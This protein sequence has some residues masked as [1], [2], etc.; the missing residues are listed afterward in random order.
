M[1][2]QKHEGKTH[3]PLS[4]RQLQKRGQERKI[5]VSGEMLTKRQKLLTLHHTERDKKHTCCIAATVVLFNHIH[6][7]ML[8]MVRHTR[9][10]RKLF[11]LF[12]Y[13]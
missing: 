8:A 6:W 13:I 9:A 2:N 12:Y 1:S 5:R 4:V 3:V 11:L 7:H 10:P